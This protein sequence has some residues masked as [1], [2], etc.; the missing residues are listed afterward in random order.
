MSSYIYQYSF[1]ERLQKLFN[2]DAKFKNTDK[3]PEY[4]TLPYDVKFI[5]YCDTVIQKNRFSYL[6]KNFFYSE[7]EDKI[8]YIN[9]YMN[10]V[11]I[12]KQNC[13]NNYM[14]YGDDGKGHYINPYNRYCN[15]KECINSYLQ[16]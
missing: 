3:D 15:I 16:K 6:T 8:Y 4:I 7:S 11:T 13:H 1:P 14:L 12:L 2:T 5:P 9:Y 10:K